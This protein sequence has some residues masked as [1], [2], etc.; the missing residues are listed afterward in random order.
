MEPEL[1]LLDK[2]CSFHSSQ[3]FHTWPTLGPRYWVRIPLPKARIRARTKVERKAK[4][5]AKART[6]RG[7]RS[8]SPPFRLVLECVLWPLSSSFVE[9]AL[10]PARRHWGRSGIWALHFVI[11]PSIV[12]KVVILLPPQL[13]TLWVGPGFFLCFDEWLLVQ[14]STIEVGP[15][16]EPLLFKLRPLRVALRLSLWPVCSQ[17]SSPP[18]R[19]ALALTLPIQLTTIEVGRGLGT[20]FYPLATPGF[21]SLFSPSAPP[22]KL[23]LGDGSQSSSPPLRLVLA[24]SPPHLESTS[25]SFFLPSYC[26]SSPG[27]PARVNPT[28]FRSREITLS[29]LFSAGCCHGTVQSDLPYPSLMKRYGVSPVRSPST[30]G[31]RCS[32]CFWA[33]FLY[34]TL[35]VALLHRRPPHLWDGQVYLVVEESLVSFFSPPFSLLPKSVWVAFWRHYSLF[36]SI[37]LSSMC[38]SFLPS[39]SWADTACTG[40]DFRDAYSM[41]ATDCVS[42]FPPFGHLFLQWSG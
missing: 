22:L 20:F 42:G 4:S 30:L 9:K 37:F 26:S 31:G 33:P 24:L 38:C 10:A 25:L 1:W 2:K 41:G 5:K 39:S 32:P 19:L 23:A 11:L 34:L 6:R 40:D 12:L 7:D 8:R 21:I 28:W 15:G 17:S 14:L 13:T 16:S 18:L 36:F 35:D 29:C 3:F 27:R